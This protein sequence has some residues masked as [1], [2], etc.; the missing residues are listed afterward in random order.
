MSKTKKQYVTISTLWYQIIFYPI[1][2]IYTNTI[3]SNTKLKYQ[4]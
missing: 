4:I 3:S 2:I 1:Y